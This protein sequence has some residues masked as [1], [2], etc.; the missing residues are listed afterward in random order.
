MQFFFGFS[1]GNVVFGMGSLVLECD[2]SIETRVIFTV[3]VV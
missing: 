2:C 3:G 1:S